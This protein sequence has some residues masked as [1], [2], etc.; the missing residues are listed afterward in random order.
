MG[1]DSCETGEGGS[2]PYYG[3][4]DI[5]FTCGNATENATSSL[6]EI[7]FQPVGCGL[8]LKGLCKVTGGDNAVFRQLKFCKAVRKFLVNK[9]RNVKIM[10]LR[11]HCFSSQKHPSAS[12]S[13]S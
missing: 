8:L 9:W 3:S 12:A 11:L 1:E 7:C 5:L 13:K 4:S 2:F 10:D 6:S